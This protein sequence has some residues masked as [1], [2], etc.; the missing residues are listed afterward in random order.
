MISEGVWKLAKTLEV[1]A[2]RLLELCLLLPSATLSMKGHCPFINLTS[3]KKSCLQSCFSLC[4]TQS[5]FIKGKCCGG[6]CIFPNKQ[7]EMDFFFFAIYCLIKTHCQLIS[8]V[9]KQI[10]VTTFHY[11]KILPCLPSWGILLLH[12]QW[13]GFYLPSLLASHWRVSNLYLPPRIFP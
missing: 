13:M 3:W 5:S 12:I 7:S 8:S 4:V 1:S 10:R 11:L 6:T 9:I 2:L